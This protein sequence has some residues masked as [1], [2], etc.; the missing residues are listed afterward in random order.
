MDVH[1]DFTVVLCISRKMF[2]PRPEDRA[3]VDRKLCSDIR[4]IRIYSNIFV[5]AN[6]YL[7]IFIFANKV[8]IYI[9]IYSNIRIS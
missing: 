9:R 1:L 5:F 4:N 6:I 2:Q 3:E 7:A 8:Q